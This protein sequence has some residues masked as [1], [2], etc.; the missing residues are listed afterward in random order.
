MLHMAK[1]RKPPM[2]ATQSKPKD[3]HKPRKAVNLKPRYHK[4]LSDLARRN[5]RNIGQELERA[6]ELLLEKEGVWPGGSGS[7]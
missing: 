3:R 4:A 5:K 1:K 7:P 2:Q 6:I